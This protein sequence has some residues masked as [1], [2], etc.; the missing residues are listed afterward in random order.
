MLEH[1]LY[2]PEAQRWINTFIEPVADILNVTYSSRC[3]GHIHVSMKN[4]NSQDLHNK[5]RFFMPIYYGLMPHRIEHGYS[6]AT[7][8]TRHRENRGCFHLSRYNTVEFRIFS[9]IESRDNLIQRL[10]LVR[11][12]LKYMSDYESYLDVYKMLFQDNELTM[13]IKN[14]ML[15]SAQVPSYDAFME[16]VFSSLLQF[17]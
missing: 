8:F 3:G 14:R 16:N 6:R 2:S 4:V 12:T 17:G 9:A 13:H 10:E 7:E 15:P 5:L 11:L 1:S